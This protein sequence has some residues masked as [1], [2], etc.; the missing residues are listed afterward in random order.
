MRKTT[1]DQIYIRD[2]FLTILIR[3]QTQ[4][5]MRKY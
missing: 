3:R 1:L 2:V 4:T 5:L